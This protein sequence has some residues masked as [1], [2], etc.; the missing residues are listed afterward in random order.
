MLFQV[1]QKLQIQ[2]SSMDFK[3]YASLSL[4]IIGLITLIFGLFQYRKSLLQKRSE[5]FLEMRKRYV[6]NTDFQKLFSMLET[7]DAKLREIPY[8]LKLRL[9]GFYE[10][11]ALLVNSK[12]IK[13]EV[14]FY[15]FAYHAIRIW[16]SNNFWSCKGFGLVDKNSPYWSRFMKFAIDMRN[17]QQLFTKQMKNDNKILTFSRIKF[18][19]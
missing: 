4:T 2:S 8:K 15:M 18:K 3:D 17:Y 9:L 16:E 10:E 1:Q 12:L 6:D 14:A 5:Q 7:D 13:K 19:L 11:L